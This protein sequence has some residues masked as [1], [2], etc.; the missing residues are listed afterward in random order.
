[1]V[2]LREGFKDPVK[3]REIEIEGEKVHLELWVRTKFFFFNLLLL[4][5][6][7]RVSENELRKD[8]ICINGDG[9]I[10]FVKEYELDKT[11]EWIKLFEGILVY[12]ETFLK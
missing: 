10:M 1:L 3:M 7:K 4:L 5:F 2:N 9:A 8:D 12:T 11:E 6:L